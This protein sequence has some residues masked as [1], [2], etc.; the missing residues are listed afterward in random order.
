[1][2]SKEEKKE[3][4][5][6]YQSAKREVQALED[7]IAELRDHKISPSMR[8]PDGMPRT[9]GV[10]DLSGY[11]ARLDELEREW[12]AKKWE[13]VDR[14]HRVCADI[15]AMP[16]ETERRL[17]QYRYING[18][19]WEQIADTMMYSYRWILKLHDRALEHLKITEKCSL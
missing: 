7:A 5:R 12:E 17:L 14:Y 19:T 3:Y 6:S 4:L 11:A 16:E 9:G 8:Q 18:K 10:S 2:K 15:L 1:M 13:A